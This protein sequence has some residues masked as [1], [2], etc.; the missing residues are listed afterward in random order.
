MKDYLFV[1]FCKTS[2]TFAGCI[3]THLK[4]R[5]PLENRYRFIGPIPVRLFMEF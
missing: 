2:E 3:W 5:N 1:M 4:Q